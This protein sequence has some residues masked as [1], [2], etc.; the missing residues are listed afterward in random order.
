[1]PLTFFPP[2]LVRHPPELAVVARSG[3]PQGVAPVVPVAD[4]EAEA[5]LIPPLLRHQLLAVVVGEAV[6][7]LQA[8]Q[9]HGSVDRLE[10]DGADHLRAAHA[11]FRNPWRPPSAG[12]VPARPTWETGV[13]FPT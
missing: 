1:M 3:V 9:R 12:P 5:F 13:L 8:A 10:D 4:V 7:L 11:T 2:L 6:F